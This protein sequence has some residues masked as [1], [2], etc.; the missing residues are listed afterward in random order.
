MV[1]EPSE[2]HF[3]KLAIRHRSWLVKSISLL[4]PYGYLAQAELD[5]GSWAQST[6][7]CQST[8]WNSIS[9][10]VEQNYDTLRLSC[11]QMVF[12]HDKTPQLVTLYTYLFI[13]YT[14]TSKYNR[15]TTCYNIRLV[16]RQ[17][18]WFIAVNVLRL[19]IGTSKYPVAVYR[20]ELYI[21]TKHHQPQA[22]FLGL[23]G[24]ENV[25]HFLQ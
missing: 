2:R 21:G 4:E 7:F 1:V 22:V 20:T 23:I 19:D 13:S 11:L 3:S 18:A 24:L 5:S 6:R 8:N 16:Y 10:F 17:T 15:A 14:Q 12:M 9:C 25:R